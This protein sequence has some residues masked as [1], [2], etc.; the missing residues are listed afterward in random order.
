ML[1]GI[2][3]GQDATKKNTVRNNGTTIDKQNTHMWE[4][5]YMN[6]LLTELFQL[7]MAG[8]SSHGHQIA[9]AIS[10]PF[11]RLE[12]LDVISTVQTPSLFIYGMAWMPWA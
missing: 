4:S 7:M 1:T 10:S 3:V 11:H 6:M 5:E 2:K 12:F 9:T 8:H